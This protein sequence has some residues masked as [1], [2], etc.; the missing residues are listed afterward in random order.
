MNF[1]TIC[2]PCSSENKLTISVC[3]DAGIIPTLPIPCGSTCSHYENGVLSCDT[4]CKN[5]QNSQYIMYGIGHSIS[6]FEESCKKSGCV[7]TK[8][9]FYND[10]HYRDILCCSCRFLLDRLSVDITRNYLL[11]QQET[12]RNKSIVILC[13]IFQNLEHFVNGGVID[14]DII[15]NTEN[16]IDEL[17]L[18]YFHTAHCKQPGCTVKNCDTMKN[19]LFAI[20]T[21]VNPNGLSNIYYSLKVLDVNHDI[22]SLI[23]EKVKYYGL[24]LHNAKCL[25]AYGECNVLG[26]DEIKAEMFGLNL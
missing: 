7:D 19:F 23:L 21:D 11:Y 4:Y 22:F 26:C 9:K 24:T 8:K 10:M 12:S 17:C 25:T 3:R 20:K 18:L 16:N 14:K 15:E 13:M 5:C 2:S 1:K 6:C